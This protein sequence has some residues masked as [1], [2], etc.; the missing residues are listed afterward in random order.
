[1]V[2]A[3]ADTPTLMERLPLKL[4]KIQKELPAWVQKGG[5]TTKATALMQNLDQQLKASNFAAAEKTA[6]SILDMLGAKP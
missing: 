5:D 2:E 3:K 6:D 1:L 4:H